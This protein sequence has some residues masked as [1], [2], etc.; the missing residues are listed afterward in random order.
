MYAL[1]QLEANTVVEG[2]V[3][4]PS[5]MAAGRNADVIKKLI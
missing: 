5:K 1:L 4:G 2:G 3:F